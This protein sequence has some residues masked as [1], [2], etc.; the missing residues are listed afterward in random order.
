MKL[1]QKQT[2]AKKIIVIAFLL[3][4]FVL[5]VIGVFSY[6]KYVDSKKKDI[7]KEEGY[8]ILDVNDPIVTSLMSKTGKTENGVFIGSEYE[9]IYY[10]D[11]KIEIKD[12]DLNLKLWIA[13]FNLDEE[14]F[15]TEENSITVSET[16]LKNKYI[17]IFGSAK[18]YKSQDI[19]YFCP[20]IIEYDTSSHLYKSSSAC[21][22]EQLSG[23]NTKIIEV[24]KY[25]T[26][27]EILEKLSFYL[28]DK[29]NNNITYWKNSNYTDIILESNVLDEF[30][31]DN[32]IEQ[33]HTYK[34]T[35]T[36]TDDHYVF[37]SVELDN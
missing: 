22:T 31:I 23:Y 10:R 21:G 2:F 11:E 36:L 3:I 29:Y 8:Q 17:E 27:I 12:L 7:E 4:I 19:I 18:D 26:K 16:A 25:K 33:L 5:I 14:Q 37:T 20:A 1:F 24:R 13:Y 34:F 15:V 28:M 30:V 9:N 35:F 6:L 32:Y